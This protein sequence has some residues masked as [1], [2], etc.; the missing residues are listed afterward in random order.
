MRIRNTSQ[1]SIA[2]LADPINAVKTVNIGKSMEVISYLQVDSSMKSNI[3]IFRPI[4]N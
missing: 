1:N 4:R 3:G 2:V